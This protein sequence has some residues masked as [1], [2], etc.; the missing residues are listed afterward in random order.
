MN[1]T[2]TKTDLVSPTLET[3]ITSLV[4]L[5]GNWRSLGKLLTIYNHPL[6]SPIYVV[7]KNFKNGIDIG[8]NRHHCE[9][10][11]S[12]LLWSESILN[13]VDCALNVVKI[14]TL[15]YGYDKFYNPSKADD[16]RATTL[17]ETILKDKNLII[18]R[19]LDKGLMHQI[20]SPNAVMF[21]LSPIFLRIIE[22]P[23]SW[24]VENLKYLVN[25]LEPVKH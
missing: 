21:F 22:N 2:K 6:P 5:M 20:E 9:P 3:K 7:C 8:Q 12:K 24:S 11:C 4:R 25:I 16:Q 23:N 13:T 19:V 17:L 14:I 1:N 10:T 18:H 15:W